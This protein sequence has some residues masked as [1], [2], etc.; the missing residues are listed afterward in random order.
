MSDRLPPPII[1]PA[2]MDDADISVYAFRLLCHLAR[3]GAAQQGAWGSVENMAVKLQFNRKTV[4]NALTELIEKG[5]IIR[6]ARPGKSSTYTFVTQPARRASPPDGPARQTGQGVARQTGQGVARQTGYEGV[7][8]RS[9]E[10]DLP[11]K[12]P[13]QE[14]EVAKLTFNP[15]QLETELQ[16]GVDLEKEKGGAADQEE[17]IRDGLKA[18]TAL[19]PLLEAFRRLPAQGL[20]SA[21]RSELLVILSSA[22]GLRVSDVDAVAK[23]V[24]HRLPLNFD[25]IARES[26]LRQVRLKLEYVLADWAAHCALAYRFVGKKKKQ[27]APDYPWQ[28]VC[29]HLYE[30][31]PVPWDRQTV[32]DKRRYAELWR[33][34]SEEQRQQAIHRYENRITTDNDS[35]SQTA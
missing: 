16:N 34:W 15:S 5:W 11:P 31:E 9:Q 29:W 6:T 8:G 2:D 3:R 7:T 4:I 32:R 18:I 24:A 26:F 28:A 10:K 22:R 17:A 14:E 27:G 35:T 1:I 21:E 33:S 13:G 25:D 20:G 30:E 19:A 23:L 12:P